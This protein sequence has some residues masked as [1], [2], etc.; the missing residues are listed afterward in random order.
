MELRET[1]LYDTREL[2]SFLVYKHK[3]RIKDDAPQPRQLDSFVGGLELKQ[4]HL[5]KLAGIHREAAADGVKTKTLN[6]GLA[7]VRR[8]SQWSHH[9]ALL[10]AELTS[11]I[12]ASEKVCD[13]ESRKAPQPPGLL[14]P[15]Q[16]PFKSHYGL[17]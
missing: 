1:R 6:M 15:G 5:G 17:D 14:G 8:A 4:V 10:Q 11:L 7:V 12:E 9:D 16:P 3:K 2:R 13:T